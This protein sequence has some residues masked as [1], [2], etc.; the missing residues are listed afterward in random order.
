LGDDFSP[1]DIGHA[2]LVDVRLE[3]WCQAVAKGNWDRF[4]LRL[5]WDDLDLETVRRAVGPVRLREGATMPEWLGLLDEAL[6]LPLIEQRKGEEAWPDEL[7]FLNVQDP[8]PF[9]EILAPF[10]LVARKRLAGR[11]T[12]DGDLVSAAAHAALER[13]LLRDLV[14]FSAELL[15]EE[16]EVM[17]A[18]ERSSWDLV[19]ALAHDPDGRSL[20][21]DFVRRM[22]DG[23]LLRLC[24]EHPVLA[25]QLGT[26]ACLWV[27]ATGELLERLVT[28]RYELE[29]FFGEDLGSVVAA[30]PSLSDPHR[31]GR[32]VV[33]LTFASGRKLVYKPKSLGAEAAYYRMLAWLNEQ[34]A[35]L[36]FRLLKILDRS[37]HGWAQFAEHLSCRDEDE[38]RRYYERAGMLLCLFYILE[39][40]DCHSEN[41]IASGEQPLLVDAE[42]LMHHRMRPRASGEGGHAQV[43]AGEQFEHSVVRTGLLP[44]WELSA[45]G[46]IA[47]DISGLCDAAEQELPYRASQWAQ[48]NTDRMVLR[49]VRATLP[50]RANVPSVN[51]APLGLR[52]HGPQLVDGFKRMY[53]FL[54]D[55]REALLGS[56][57]ELAHEEVR[58]VYRPTRVYTILLRNLRGRRYL[59]DGADR[60]IYLEH[61]GRTQLSVYGSRPVL[62]SVFAAERRAM[63]QG[64]IPFFT[65]RADS[66]ALIVAPGQQI[67]GSFLEPSFEGVLRRLEALGEEDLDRQVAFIEGSLYTYS[68]RGTTAAPRFVR[69]ADEEDD[70]TE[71]PSPEAFVKPAL[72]LADAIRAR[73]VRAKDGSATWISPQYLIQADRYQLQLMGYDLYGGTCGVALFLAAAE[74][75]STLGG[76]GELAMA[77]LRPLR[78]ELRDRPERLAGIMGIGGGSGL[79]SV[80]YS[81]VRVSRLLDEPSLMEDACRA[82]GLITEA[83]ITAD[84]NLDVLSGAAGAILGLVTLYEARPNR[85]FLDRAIACGAHLVDARTTSVVGSRTWATLGGLLHTGFSHG[86]A[87]IT[88]ALLRLYEH[89]QDSRLLEAAKEGIAYEDAAYSSKT[90]NW[91]SYYR[92]G[93]PSYAWQWCYGAP[94]IGLA[95]LG[96]LEVLNTEWVREDIELSL[97]AAQK[98][99][100]QAVDHPCCGNLSRAEVL[101]AAG[102]RLLRPELSELGRAYA[103]RAATRAEQASGFRLHP[104]LPRHV[105]S[106]GFFQGT[107]GIGYELLRMAR[108]SLLPS[109]LMWE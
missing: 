82:A 32:T 96:V 106:L 83:R 37:T 87:G 101:L 85:E 80:V 105:D 9:E 50:A 63:E 40:T 35:P 47:H 10:V 46:R 20:Y 68:A 100:M 3:A 49:W 65:A 86:A 2:D 109:V 108:P 99:G 38:A 52:D 23:E 69:A 107:S 59:R 54:L 74:R 77:A 67:E 66:D 53:R 51:G 88:Y 8:L 36:S 5:A 73:A 75:F 14:T 90:G 48:V 16:F 31:G 61:L 102:E 7:G 76:Y 71:P 78:G 4:R 104:L 33:V 39:V 25:R 91:A 34:G 58:F 98:V 41:I 103:W 89:T 92:D 93:E 81:L 1:A 29:R 21:L 84:E 12:T 18:Q 45:D 13:G 11:A 57:H 22:A 62:W 44:R 64:D 55:H 79:G 60:S 19:L 24:L 42:T 17:R 27:E 28:D 30:Q 94:G 43:L 72:T 6:R 15:L 26:I 56:L 97:Q 70:A 95:R